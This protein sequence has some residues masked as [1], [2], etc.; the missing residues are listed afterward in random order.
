MFWQFSSRI[1]SYYLSSEYGRLDDGDLPSLVKLCS[2]VDL[3]F[4]KDGWREQICIIAPN[5]NNNNNNR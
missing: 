5:S 1:D 2:N 4:C 3:L